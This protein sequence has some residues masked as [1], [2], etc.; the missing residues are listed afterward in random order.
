MGVKIKWES[1]IKPLIKKYRKKSHPLK[2]HNLYECMVMVILSAQSSDDYI[3]K[4]APALFDEF[5]D[6][7][8]LA[9]AKDE[10]VYPFVKGVIGHVKKIKYL[11]DIAKQLKSNKNI[12]VT[13]EALVALPGIGRKSANVIMR[14]AGVKAEGIVVDLHTVRVATRLGISKSDDPKKIEQ[15][16][17]KKIEEKDWGEAGMAMSF[18]G[19][20]ICR[21]KPLC[22]ECLM[23]DVCVFYLKGGYEKLQ[24][25]LT[26]GKKSG[27]VRKKGRW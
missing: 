18:L 9:K 12:P 6:L 5:P 24:K 21:P 19:R 10:Q 8:S 25:E 4:I 16:C 3:N 22:P 13:M 23:N 14:E 15:D 26:K 1:A 17:M 27:G 7:N 11:T 20:E 2:H